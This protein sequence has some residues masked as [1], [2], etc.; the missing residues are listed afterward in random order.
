MVTAEQEQRFPFEKKRELC[1]LPVLPGAEDSNTVQLP[2]LHFSVNYY[3]LK[4]EH[5][6]ENAKSYVFA[7]LGM[8]PQIERL[9]GVFLSSRRKFFL[10]VGAY[11]NK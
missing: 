2:K 5:K 4:I 8:A 6:A 3:T 7:V 10:A 9:T 1:S 11:I